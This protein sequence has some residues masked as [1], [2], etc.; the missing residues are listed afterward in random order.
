M[1]DLRQRYGQALASTCRA[2]E[3]GLHGEDGCPRCAARLD[4]VLAVRD[5][6]L[7]EL[8]R[9]VADYESAICFGTS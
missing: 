4:A 8:R 7:A 3:L 9:R 2:H 6:E 5:D 1:A